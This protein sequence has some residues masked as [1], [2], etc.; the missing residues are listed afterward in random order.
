MP[1]SVLTLRFIMSLYTCLFY[2]N[3]IF[4]FPSTLYIDFQISQKKQY[5]YIKSGRTCCESI[6]ARDFTLSDFILTDIDGRR[7][8]YCRFTTYQDA[9]RV[10]FSTVLIFETNILRVSPVKRPQRSLKCTYLY[11]YLKIS[12]PSRWTGLPHTETPFCGVLDLADVPTPCSLLLHACCSASS[13][14]MLSTPVKTKLCPFT[15]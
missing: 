15:L 5:L 10:V 13:I 12:P 11:L 14:V 2:L 4:S 7:K 3:Y 8:H 6:R 1:A 9:H